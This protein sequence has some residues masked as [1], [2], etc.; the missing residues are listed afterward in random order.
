M[1]NL[2]SCL[3]FGRPDIEAMEDREDALR[4]QA[5]ENG[6]YDD[7]HLEECAVCREDSDKWIWVP[8]ADIG[9]EVS[10]VCLS[11]ANRVAKALRDAWQIGGVR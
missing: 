4:E 1:F 10:P 11:C 2:L 7:V 9:P 8:L 3:G 6:T 5:F